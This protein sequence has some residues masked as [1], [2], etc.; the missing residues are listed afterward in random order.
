MKIY[1]S[2]LLL[3]LFFATP[4]QSNGQGDTISFITPLN[5]AMEDHQVD[6]ENYS[7]QLYYPYDIEF[8]E[9]SC[10][11]VLERGS[12]GFI[13]KIN[14]DGSLTHLN[15]STLYKPYAMTQSSDSNFYVADK[16]R[17]VKITKQGTTS[18]V[19]TGFSDLRDIIQDQ[20]GNFF[21][22]EY[23]SGTVKKVTPLG[24]I[25]TFVSGLLQPYGITQ[26][27]EGNF[28]VAESNAGTIKK[29]TPTGTVTTFISD[30]ST[31]AGITYGVD[32]HLYA[33]EYLYGRVKSINPNGGV[34]TITEEFSSPYAIT[35]LLNGDLYVTDFSKYA[36]KISF[37][38]Q[39][40]VNENA[41]S[42]T[43][44]A[45]V[46][47]THSQN[48]AL[49]FSLEQ[50]PSNAIFSI[51]NEGLIWVLD[52]SKLDFESDSLYSLTVTVNDG[53]Y[54]T[55][56]ELT[57]RLIDQLE[58]PTISIITAEGIA[59]DHSSAIVSSLFDATSTI[60]DLVQGIDG[61][62]YVTAPVSSLQA[63]SIKRFNREGSNSVF[64]SNLSR[65]DHICSNVDGS[66]YI[67][68]GMSA[69]NKFLKKVYPDGRV[70]SIASGFSKPVG[71]VSAPN[72]T[73][74]V[75]EQGGTIKK[76]TPE[77]AVSIL[78]NALGWTSGGI[79]RDQTGNLYTFSAGRLKK[80]TPEGSISDYASDLATVN[81]MT[82]GA[83]SAIYISNRLSDG[84]TLEKVRPKGRTT[85]LLTDL[86][87]SGR[88]T[89]GNDGNICFIANQKVKQV[90]FSHRFLLREN[91]AYPAVIGQVHA[92]DPNGDSL[93]FA[94]VGGNEDKTF[95]ID[96][97]GQLTLANG[98]VIDYETRSSYTL[99]VQVSDGEFTHEKQLDIL[100]TDVAEQPVISDIV[101]GS[102]MISYD[103]LI[104]HSITEPTGGTTDLI[105]GADGHLYAVGGNSL[106]QITF[107]G[108]ITTITNQLDNPS[109]IT[110]SPE[111]GFYVSTSQS[112]NKVSPTG[113]INQYLKMFYG[114]SIV[115]H[116]D[117]TLYIGSSRYITKVTAE[118][119]VIVFENNGDVRLL[120]YGQLKQFN[121]TQTYSM[122]QRYFSRTVSL[123]TEDHSA[124]FL[125][126]NE[127]KERVYLSDHEKASLRIFAYPNSYKL[128]KCQDGSFVYYDDSQLVR[129][130]TKTYRIGIDEHTADSTLVARIVA[131]HPTNR[132]LTYRL[133]SSG[134]E[135]VFHINEHTGDIR[136]ANS[137]ALDFEHQPVYDLTVRVSEG[138]VSTTQTITIHLIDLE[139]PD[140]ILPDQ[141]FTL[142]SNAS[143]D[144]FVG[145]VATNS[146]Q[147]SS[148]RWRIVS[149][150]EEGIFQLDTLSGAIM[151]AS[152]EAL[153]STTLHQ[154][155]L[156]VVVADD[157]YIS[158]PQPISIFIDEPDQTR[159]TVS[160]QGVKND[161]APFEY[162]L[163]IAFS[164]FVRDFKKESIFTEYADVT[165]MSTL[166]SIHFFA[167]VQTMANYN[168]VIRVP[169]GVA[170]DSSGNL[171]KSSQ[172]FIVVG[173]K[174][175]VVVDS[176]T[177]EIDTTFTVE[178]SLVLPDTLNEPLLSKATLYQKID[179]QVHEVAFHENTLGDQIV[180]TNLTSG[181]YTLGIDFADTAYHP[182]YFGDQ[183]LQTEA[184]WVYLDQDTLLSVL[185]PDPLLPQNSDG[186]TITGQILLSDAGQNGRIAVYNT[187]QEGDAIMNVSVYLLSSSDRKVIEYAETNEKGGFVFYNIAVGDYLLVADYQGLPND[188]QKNI[189][190]VESAE[191]SL[192]I[193]VLVAQSIQI[194]DSFSPSIVTTV[195]EVEE[196]IEVAYFPNPVTNELAIV[197]PDQWPSAVLMINDVSGRLLHTQKIEKNSAYVRLDWLAP[198]VYTV[199]VMR[200]NHLVMFKMTK[201]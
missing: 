75:I 58:S 111:G 184:K 201:R 147:S 84:P 2:G 46:H 138:Q 85:T 95:A 26:D 78:T 35:Q 37:R 128:L 158:N 185:A 54:S 77:G 76:V 107:S 67:I 47:T 88:I 141:S 179:E 92:N 11:Y 116:I 27:R 115:Q 51:D 79:I 70:A 127:V 140:I 197:L 16:D 65:V 135:G 176:S 42:N 43:A 100:V 33:V 22:T 61:N 142:Y 29:I 62:F 64:V 63:G 20:D 17:I 108:Q 50:L 200:K 156:T 186:A 14:Q 188:E 24:V 181:V 103:S 146:D 104:M 169:E 56:A 18:V 41:S 32:D 124:L 1:L 99:T 165:T 168:S 74:F 121:S 110:Q 119:T 178:I 191:A 134:P 40:A 94:I 117:S 39:I 166:D 72:N 48:K 31:L 143:K 120:E 38:Y 167:Q 172:D 125:N 6:I 23:T 49:T 19:A 155:T 198:G 187:A 123:T 139:E 182:I 183:V 73:V 193:T 131:F 145:Q 81:G 175:F 60:S 71:L 13:R 101:T 106:K 132:S 161:Q 137:R 21:V 82:I 66:F 129:R 90:S 174:D 52:G 150:N 98:A 190:S 170:K 80:V 151:V 15:H 122:L 162:Q 96:Q 30:L 97:F 195:T 44:I 10:F 36:R 164:E 154:Q 157:G 68:D 199:V 8:G 152:S 91:T 93:N 28:Y 113:V 180:F 69:S 194:V 153:N 105:Q 118:D 86:V 55:Q 59:A 196:P 144:Q 3:I 25:S 163:T 189:I 57:V 89:T 159:P 136:V 114:G 192:E 149:G 130:I 148:M 87:S 34:R 4:K 109:G 133:T 126:D 9:D 45:R 12:Y 5:G 171:N 102:K 173:S 7:D 177:T 83:D 53:S 112:L 160:I